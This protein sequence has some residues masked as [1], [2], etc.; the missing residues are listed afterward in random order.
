MKIESTNCSVHM[1]HTLTSF[2]TELILCIC[3]LKGRKCAS[4]EE[5]IMRVFGSRS[6]SVS[7]C[8]AFSGWWKIGNQHKLFCSHLEHSLQIEVPD[9][10]VSLFTSWK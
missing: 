1:T 9:I 3:G 7:H 10:P 5:G 2:S 6:F 4:G 8:L